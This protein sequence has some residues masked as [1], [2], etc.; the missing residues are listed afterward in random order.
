MLLATSISEKCRNG[1]VPQTLATERRAHS[2]HNL[3]VTRTSPD[4][5]LRKQAGSGHRPHES[6]LGNTG[7]VTQTL[8]TLTPIAGNGGPREN[9]LVKLR[10]VLSVN[11]TVS[12]ERLRCQRSV[13][14]QRVGLIGPI[15]RF[16]T[17]TLFWIERAILF[18]PLRTKQQALVPASNRVCQE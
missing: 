9:F 7:R 10:T 1:E 8:P 3:L 12:S 11:S 14:K 15:R 5:R 18:C 13:F 2:E 6:V 4:V 16:G 17:G